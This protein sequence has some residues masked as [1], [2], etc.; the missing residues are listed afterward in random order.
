ML[1]ALQY[2]HEEG[3]ARLRAI[4][5]LLGVATT[6]RLGTIIGF[7]HKARAALGQG[8]HHADADISIL[9]ATR[10][11]DLGQ[12]KLIARLIGIPFG[13]RKNSAGERLE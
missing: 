12:A 7:A 11:F 13:S 3:V 4:Q 5:N 10:D 8:F 9:A 6:H 2:W 1:L